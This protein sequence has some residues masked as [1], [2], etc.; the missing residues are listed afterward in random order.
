MK[1]KTSSETGQ[2]MVLLAIAF[3]GLLAFAA[4]AIDVGMVYS[5]RRYAQNVA[6]SAALAGVNSAGTII[7]DINAVDFNCS[8]NGSVVSAIE[9]AKV[10][11]VA[12]AT[13]NKIPITVQDLSTAKHG[14]Q[15][16]CDSTAK[17]IDVKVMITTDTK[18]SFIQLFNNSPLRN[19][20]TS[21]SRV[22]PRTPVAAGNTIVSLSLQADSLVIKGTVTIGIDNGGIHS[23]G[24][25]TKSG[26]SGSIKVEHGT[27]S[28]V[29]T[30]DTFDW[31]GSTL[32]P[33]APVMAKPAIPKPNCNGVTNRTTGNK[34]ATGL[35]DPGLYENGIAA[36]TLKPGLYCL[37]GSI[38]L[39]GSDVLQNQ[40]RDGDHGVTI[41]MLEGDVDMLGNSGAK[42][43]APRNV[44]PSTAVNGAIPGLL[45]YV[46]E[47]NSCNTTTNCIKL[48]GTND[49]MYQG[50]VFVPN[51]HVDMGGTNNAAAPWDTQIIAYTVG[52]NGT[53]NLYINSTTQNNVIIPTS[54]QVQQ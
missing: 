44:N 1:T 35:L 52:F 34:A 14:V 50:T 8:S 27:I 41:M 39:N 49:G 3:M 19:T 4:L 40:T 45:F 28:A 47:N 54:M 31:Q 20:V 9:A 37:R 42:L 13:A 30:I 53:P 24:S 38:S 15:I 10:A 25:I 29:G 18:P 17:Y 43:Y 51:G 21:V 5:D 36:A 23:N 16:I 2:I 11:A 12:R 46:D 6:D 48:N 33:H 22:I 7:R 32:V 26:A